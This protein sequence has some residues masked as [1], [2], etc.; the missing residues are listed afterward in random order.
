ML[1][2]IAKRLR[3]PHYSNELEKIMHYSPDN[4][5]CLRSRNLDPKELAEHLRLVA[6]DKDT[7]AFRILFEAI[8][9]RIKALMLRQGMDNAGAEDVA[10]ETMVIL[11]RKAHFYAEHR[12]SVFTWAFTIARNLRI[13]SLRKTRFAF[14][15]L[16]DVPEPISEDATLLAVTQRHQEDVRVRAALRTL[17]GK[18][19]EVIELAFIHGLSHSEIAERLGLPVGTVK[20]RIRMAFG[21]LRDTLPELQH[22]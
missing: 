18:H 19:K 21:R 15:N 12:G 6:T 14:A 5:R 8:A 11:W 4:A 1:S 22:A 17:P 7:A 20:S 9:P 16:A 10:Q 3:D 13:D 2:A